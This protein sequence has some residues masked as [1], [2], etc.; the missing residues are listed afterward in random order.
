MSVKV[1]FPHMG[2][3]YIP[4]RALLESLGAE[5]VVPERPNRRTVSVGARH[6]PESACLPFKVTLGDCMDALE[7]GAELLAMVG[8]MWACRFGHYGRVQHMILRDL[9]YRFQSLI[10]SRENVGEVLEA[11]R[12]FLGPEALR[13]VPAALAMFRAK[14][15]AVEEV[16][17]WVRWARP[18]EEVSGSADALCDRVLAELDGADT[19]RRVRELRRLFRLEVRTLSI[20]RG[21]EPLRLRLVGE[22]YV[23]LEPALNH[24]L[25]RRLGS[26]HRAEV[27]PVLSTYRWLLGPLWLDP[28]IQFTGYVARRRARPYLPYVLG[29]EEHMTLAGILTA[30]REGFHGVIHAYPLTCM[31]ENV[32]RAV[33]PGIPAEKRLPYLSLCI[34]E[35]TSAAGME[36]R[37]EAFL[38]LVRSS[39]Q[40]SE[41][42]RAVTGAYIPGSLK[43]AERA[44]PWAA[45]NGPLLR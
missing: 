18:R 14:A 16:E 32:C 33:I 19:L 5:A 40:A 27:Q 12:R 43:T 34:D 20:D 9:G 11:L 17:R 13:R 25:V 2:N 1:A 36:V 23:L 8:G 15:A 6:A 29:G 45:R 21:F 31:P 35:H 37:L 3:A 24:D 38:D 44:F 26:V 10:I 39:R 28:R 4:L 7:R 30:A 22:L 42:A 41:G